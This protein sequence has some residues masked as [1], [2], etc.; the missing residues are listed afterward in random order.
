MRFV[1][2][3]HVYDTST[4]EKIHSWTEKRWT[5]DAAV[6]MTEQEARAGKPE[7]SK[8]VKCQSVAYRS[9]KGTYFVVSTG[10]FSGSPDYHVLGHPDD[11][12]SYVAEYLLEKGVSME[13]LE[14]LG[15][16]FEEG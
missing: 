11:E 15:F 10:K 14:K 2:N 5:G 4:S 12:Y 13:K 16:M 3:G 9:P 8:Y 6:P 7:K 1:R